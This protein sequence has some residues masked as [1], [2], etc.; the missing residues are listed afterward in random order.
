VSEHDV[1]EAF[2]MNGS[3]GA[4]V[5]ALSKDS[6]RS[7]RRF[8]RLDEPSAAIV[9]LANGVT[10]PERPILAEKLL[11]GFRSRDRVR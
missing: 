11:S 2:A 4:A 9:A 5:A 1:Q 3:L 7:L 10:D 8:A 6:G